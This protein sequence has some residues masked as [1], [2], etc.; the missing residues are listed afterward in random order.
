M[1]LNILII[2]SLSNCIDGKVTQRKHNSFGVHIMHSTCNKTTLNMYQ[3]MLYVEVKYTQL[4]TS[5]CASI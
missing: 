3:E 4:H 2:V 1:H 5:I